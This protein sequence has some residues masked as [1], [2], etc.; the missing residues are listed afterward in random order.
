MEAPHCPCPVGSLP[1]TPKSL[2]LMKSQVTNRTHTSG[3][4]PQP[5]PVNEPDVPQGAHRAGQIC[6]KPEANAT[7]F[8][9]EGLKTVL[10]LLF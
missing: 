9:K 2:S 8:T 6:G 3:S 7:P 5:W 1:G 4:C 10:V